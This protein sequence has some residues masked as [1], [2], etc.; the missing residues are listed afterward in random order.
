MEAAANLGLDVPDVHELGRRLG[1]TVFADVADACDR[2][3]MGMRN[4]SDKTCDKLELYLLNNLVLI[5]DDLHVPGVDPDPIADALS[6]SSSSSSAPA[7][8]TF[9][10]EDETR[11]DDER[12]VLRD[13]IIRLRRKNARV[14]RTRADLHAQL[15]RWQKT[16]VPLVQQVTASVSAV[17]GDDAGVGSSSSAGATGPSLA[18]AVKAVLRDTQ[19]LTATSARVQGG[20]CCW[21]RL[22][23]FG[24]FCLFVSFVTHTV[25]GCFLSFWQCMP[26]PRPRSCGTRAPSGWRSGRA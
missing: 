11:L 22:P 16:M 13:R 21:H 9:T 6:S 24:A 4:Q 3:T 10:E 17:L 23:F 12:A 26:Q 7:H 18:D 25:F 8:T 15:E 20:F 5:P 1:S 19:A 2:L 14:A